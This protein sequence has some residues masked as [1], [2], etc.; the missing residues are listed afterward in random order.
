MTAVMFPGRGEDLGAARAVCAECEVT[1]ECLDE[2][3]AMSSMLDLGV[4]A[5]TSERQRRRLRRER[6]I[7]HRAPGLQRH[8]GEDTEDEAEVG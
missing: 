7:S 2:G 6:H 5:G 4:R 3:L 8:Y 1:S